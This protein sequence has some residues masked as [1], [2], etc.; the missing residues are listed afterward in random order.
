[1][2]VKLIYNFK[3]LPKAYGAITLYP[4]I[5]F[6]TSKADTFQSTIKHEM[7]HVAQVREAGWFCFYI[8]YL[9]YFVAGYIR[10]HNWDRAYM[11]IPYEIEAREL[12]DTPLIYSQ[13][14]ELGLLVGPS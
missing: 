14:K 9:I 4:F 8:S 10:Y 13:R 2:K 11:Q 7:V 12:E 6:T 3:L 5:F 1:M